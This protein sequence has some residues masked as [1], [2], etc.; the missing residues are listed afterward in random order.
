MLFRSH[1]TYDY[2]LTPLT[3]L[4]TRMVSVQPLRTAGDRNQPPSHSPTRRDKK[5]TIVRMQS[6]KL[7]K[8]NLHPPSYIPYNVFSKK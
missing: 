5:F 4:T 7:C 2:M 1:P 6:W 3:H 8:K